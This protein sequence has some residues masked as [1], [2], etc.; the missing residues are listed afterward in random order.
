[1]NVLKRITLRFILI[2]IAT[3][4]ATSLLIIMPLEEVYAVGKFV[5]FVRKIPSNLS[6]PP[7]DLAWTGK[8]FIITTTKGGALNT[9]S[10]KGEVSPFADNCFKLEGYESH[11]AI[12]GP[13][14]TDFGL[15]N[16]YVSNGPLIWRINPTGS[17]CTVFANLTSPL[18]PLLRS[19][20]THTQLT[21]D[22]QGSFD[23]N[24]IAS[25]NDGSVWTINH[26]GEF[27]LL[28][29]KLGAILECL[30]VAPPDFGPISGKLIVGS[31]DAYKIYSISKAG[32]ISPLKFVLSPIG[33]INP[34]N[35]HCHFLPRHINISNPTSGM[36]ISFFELNSIGN[37]SSILKA[38]MKAFAK[39]PGSFIL[40]DETG[41]V[42][43]ITFDSTTKNY[44]IRDNPAAFEA[45]RSGAHYKWEGSV[46][47]NNATQI[48]D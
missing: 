48:S 9:I 29:S 3:S 40:T 43:A 8:Q 25:T 20:L 34:A 39:Y 37:K 31:Q 7:S 11:I 21:F 16:I 13:E 28:A 19:T 41:I 45:P 36:Y 47:V 18:A 35:E 2:I 33:N 32:E 12:A 30:E 14:N 42:S 24:L 15:G 6:Y 46:F 27:K 1:M 10:T 5:P 38:P 4:F 22:R 26:R 17:I 44:V 23:K